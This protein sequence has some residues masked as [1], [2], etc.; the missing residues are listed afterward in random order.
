MA[1]DNTTEKQASEFVEVALTDL[2][3]KK[4]AELTET[5]SRLKEAAAKEEHY[6]TVTAEVDAAREELIR[7]NTEIKNREAATDKQKV[8]NDKATHD[9]YQVH[10]AQAKKEGELAKRE[11][12]V[13]A[14]EKESEQ[15]ERSLTSREEALASNVLLVSDEKTKLAERDRLITDRESRLE[16]RKT[17][18]SAIEKV[19][20]G[21]A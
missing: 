15:K 19:R 20:A 17:K 1:K 11:L 12:Q 16:E 8:E 4:L 9:L 7:F 3:Q 18:F 21:Q 6:T 13:I 10:E 2:A 14:R 5:Q